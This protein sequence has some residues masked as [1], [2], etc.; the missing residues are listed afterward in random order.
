MDAPVNNPDDNVAISS[1]SVVRFLLDSETSLVEPSRPNMVHLFPFPVSCLTLYRHHG[2]DAMGAP[3]RLFVQNAVFEALGLEVFG[4]E[5][6]LLIQA[7]F[8]V[9]RHLQGKRRST[10]EP[11]F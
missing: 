7:A 4:S 10:R 1:A 5:R 9:Q 3:R 2:C 6:R 11:E 8:L